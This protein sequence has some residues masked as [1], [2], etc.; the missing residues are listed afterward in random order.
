[1][2]RWIVGPV[3]VRRC[4]QAAHVDAPPDD[5]AERTLQDARQPRTAG[6]PVRRGPQ[7]DLRIDQVHNAMTRMTDAAELHQRLDHQGFF[8]VDVMSG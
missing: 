4:V 6:P 2:S 1:M 5:V 7:S 8:D 3:D